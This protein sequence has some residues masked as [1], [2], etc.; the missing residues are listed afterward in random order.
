MCFCKSIESKIL[1]AKRDIIVYKLGCFASS[2]L[3][4]PIY[5]TAY[6]YYKN[7]TVKENVLFNNDVIDI[8][9]HSYINCKIRPSKNNHF[10]YIKLYYIN[11]RILTCYYLNEIFLGKFIIPKGATYC[12]NNSYEVV[13]DSIIYTGNY[14]RL[15]DDISI[16]AKDIWK[17]KQEKY[18]LIKIKHIKQF[19][20]LN[21]QNVHLHIYYVLL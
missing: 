11:N 5:I 13:S 3:F 7:K 8:G 20:A 15:S 4:Y 2:N 1:I 18:L 6:C 14:I 12:M 21:V 19:K 10:D 9:F 17:E 16:N